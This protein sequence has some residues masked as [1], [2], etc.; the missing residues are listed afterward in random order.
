ML[1]FVTKMDFMWNS[2]IRIWVLI[3]MLGISSISCKVY[4]ETKTEHRK[5]D[6]NSTANISADSEINNLIQPYKQQ[7]DAK[8]NEVIGVAEKE[9][10]KQAPEC[11]LGKL[12]SGCSTGSMQFSL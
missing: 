10:V 9:L 12:G 2:N 5:Y 4:H 8:M 6:L 3:L 1:E 7:L 11:T